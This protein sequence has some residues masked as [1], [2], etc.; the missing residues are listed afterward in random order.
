MFSVSLSMISRYG[1]VSLYNVT[2]FLIYSIISLFYLLL[3]VMLLLASGVMLY[4]AI[5][6]LLRCEE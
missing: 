3:A 6:V 2:E 1:A 5:V 4:G